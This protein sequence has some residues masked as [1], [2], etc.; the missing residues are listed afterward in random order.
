MGKIAQV[1]YD[2]TLAAL[3]EETDDGFTM[4]YDKTYLQNPEGKSVSVTLPLSEKRYES[5]TL[6]AFFDGLIPEGWLLNIA[7]AHWKIKANDRYELLLTS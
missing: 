3:L 1:M 6:F 7:T 4:T 2:G 5:K